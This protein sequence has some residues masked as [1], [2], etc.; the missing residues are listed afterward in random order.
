MKYLVRRTISVDPISVV[1]EVEA[2]SYEEASEKAAD[3]EAFKELDEIDLQD[4]LSF[5]EEVEEKEN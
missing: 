4:A 2:N 5:Q 3:H 1:V